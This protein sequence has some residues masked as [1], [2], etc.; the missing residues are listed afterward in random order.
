MFSPKRAIALTAAAL[1]LTAAGG[2]GVASAHSAATGGPLTYTE[3][4][5]QALSTT[6][7]DYN[8]DANTT[9][10]GVRQCDR[11]SDLEFNCVGHL[12]YRNGDTCDFTILTWINSYADSTT[13][14]WESQVCDR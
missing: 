2:T 12:D 3:A 13:H 6:I 9:N 10:Y 4:F 5:N 7:D 8:A 11:V 1:A 14:V